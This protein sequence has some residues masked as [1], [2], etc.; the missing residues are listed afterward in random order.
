M[1]S[2]APIVLWSSAFIGDDFNELRRIGGEIVNVLHG[3]RGT[4]DASIFQEPPIPQIAIDIDRAATARYGINVSDVTNLIQTGIGGAP[5]SKVYVADRTYDVTVRFPQNT[6][7][8]PEALGN[9]V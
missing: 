1:Q 6:R 2:A 8:N 5:V 4:A 9:L 3:I 7:N